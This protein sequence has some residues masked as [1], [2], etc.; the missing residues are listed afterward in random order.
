MCANTGAS[1]SVTGRLAWINT[2]SIWDDLNAN[3]PDVDVHTVWIGLKSKTGTNARPDMYWTDNDGKA[4]TQLTF[5]IDSEPIVG[6]F[7][8]R[9]S[10]SGD[11]VAYSD[12]TESNSDWE[13]Y[14]CSDTNTALCELVC[15]YAAT[16]SPGKHAVAY[17]I[18]IS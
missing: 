9:Q 10:A 11:C 6:M 5:G 14:Q 8:L 7:R 15:D 1:H 12:L 13:T 18:K 17:S 2:Q 4:V 3:A 16:M